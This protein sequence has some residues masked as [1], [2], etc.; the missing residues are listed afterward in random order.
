MRPFVS[1]I[2]LEEMV[3]SQEGYFTLLQRHF[4]RLKLKMQREYRQEIRLSGKPMD[5]FYLKI[6]SDFTL[7]DHNGDLGPATFVYCILELCEN[8][9]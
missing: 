5:N 7:V 2:P 6:I 3:T 9:S 1:E 8:G 4:R